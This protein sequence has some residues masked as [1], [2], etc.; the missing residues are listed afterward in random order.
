MTKPVLVFDLDGT[1]ADTARDLIPVLNRT[2]A[3]RGLEPI[4][5]NMIGNMV[6]HGARAM[7]A[8]AYAVHQ[9]ELS[10]SEHDALFD[11]FIAD[12]SITL[13][14]NTV[15]FEGAQL[16]LDSLAAAGFILA[17]CTNKPE[18]LA[19]RLLDSLGVL[20]RF[21]A[22]TGGDTYPWRKPDPRHLTD[23][24]KLAGFE[25]RNAIMVGDS[26]TDID[27]AKAAGIPVIAVDFGYTD[28]PVHELGPDQVI[29]HF[30]ELERAVS[31]IWQR[32]A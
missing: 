32:R 20:G 26:R 28:I 6:G 29:S 17:V 23:T 30:N 10:A 31:A 14:D 3:K 4:P 7:I 2:T 25:P 11:M 21:V 15:L 1:L 18:K 13:A 8:K 24:V 27:T 9:L 5:A 12:Y 16:A 22:L 19:T